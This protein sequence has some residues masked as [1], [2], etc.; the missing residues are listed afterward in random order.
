MLFSSLISSKSTRKHWKLCRFVSLFDKAGRNWDTAWQ[1]E[2]TPWDL[3]APTPALV[4]FIK[5]PFIKLKSKH[6]LIPGCGSGHDCLLLANN[7]FQNVVGLDLSS[8]AIDIAKDLAKQ[9]TLTNI[10]YKVANFFEYRANRPLDFIFDYL[11]FAA[12]DPPERLNWASSMESLL[13]K[14]FGVL[15]TLIFPLATEKDDRTVGP[16]YPVSLEDYQAVLKPSNWEI[17]RIDKV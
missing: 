14:E 13:E 10:E 5:D 3:K 12:I 7:G 11:F 16:P 9:E 15:A 17:I 8:T 4:D 1:T 6:A 2:L